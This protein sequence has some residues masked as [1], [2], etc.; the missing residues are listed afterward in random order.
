MLEKDVNR[1][2]SILLIIGIVCLPIVFAWFTLKDGYSKR[3]RGISFVWLVVS[4]I[5]TMGNSN[6]SS[7]LA[8]E[9][10][11]QAQEKN[12]SLSD[13]SD[14]QLADHMYINSTPFLNELIQFLDTTNPATKQDFFNWDE[15]T[16]FTKRYNDHLGQ[17]PLIGAGMENYTRSRLMVTDYMYQ[18]NKLPLKIATFLE[19]KNEQYK[20]EE[21]EPLLTKINLAAKTTSSYCSNK[22]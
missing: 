20:K 1:K 10:S 12:L 3:A 4:L 9:S 18:I 22:L 15:N 5:L 16:N 6:E 7:N 8:K 19:D 21:I 13:F 2:V 17:Y 14:C 11:M